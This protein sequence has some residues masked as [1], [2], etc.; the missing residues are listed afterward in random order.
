MY[1]KDCDE[2]SDD[3]EEVDLERGGNIFEIFL[4]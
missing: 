4:G 1:D 2:F 3:G